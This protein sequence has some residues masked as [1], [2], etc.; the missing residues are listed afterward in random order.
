MSDAQTSPG[1]NTLVQMPFF[2]PSHLPCRHF[3]PH[4][5]SCILVQ[6]KSQDNGPFRRY[7]AFQ[8][9]TKTGGGSSRKRDVPGILERLE[10]AKRLAKKASEWFL[11]DLISNT[12]SFKEKISCALQFLIKS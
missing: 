4:L 9:E 8:I 6:A 11:Q 7:N 5:F 2:L 1:L 10:K 12:L 3:E